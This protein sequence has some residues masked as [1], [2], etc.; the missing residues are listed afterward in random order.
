MKK[1]YIVR[2]IVLVL[3]ACAVF[4]SSCTAKFNP[5]KPP[6]EACY[7]M[8]E[9]HPCDFTLM[10]QNGNQVRL[11]DYYGK[12][13]VL[14]FSVMWCGPCQMAAREIDNTVSKFGED[15][16]AYITVLIEN[17]FG[18][19]P[20]LRDLENW[21]KENK[22][23]L[24]PVLGGSRDFLN[25]SD[26]KITGWPTF[27]FIDQDMVLQGELTG[28]SSGYINQNIEILLQEQDT[29]N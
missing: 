8:T 5:D 20:D 23:K 28:Y 16:V 18:K 15:E 21:A 17:S 12:I 11:Y 19:D 22:I 29:G 1:K 27:F 14:D 10:D 26:W 4:A 2:L 25:A 6:W 7:G 3:L 9:E 13:I 24:G